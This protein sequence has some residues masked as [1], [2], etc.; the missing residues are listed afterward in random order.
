M[1]NVSNA[2]ATLVAANHTLLMKATLTLADSTV[3]NLTSDDF[4]AGSARFEQ[5]V[6]SDGSFDI[7]G[8]IVGTMS[9][10]LAN[11]GGKFDSYDLGGA[12]IIPYV[13]KLLPNNSYEWLRLGT[14]DVVK[15]DYYGGTI[16]ITCYDVLNRLASHKYSELSVTYPIYPQALLTA[17]GTHCGFT[18][19]YGTSPV[20]NTVSI[21]RAPDMEMTLLDAAGYLAQMMGYWLV[22]DVTGNI[23]ANWYDTTA[24]DPG[25]TPYAITDSFNSMFMTEDV[26]ITGVQV[27]ETDEVTLD[28]DNNEVNGN[29]GGTYLSGTSD[30]CLTIPS[31]PFIAY[32]TGQTVAANLYSRVGGMC[33]RPYNNS[34]PCDPVIEAGD[35]VVVTDRHGDTHNAYVTGVV[36]KP[37]GAMETRSTAKSPAS[38]SNLSA[39][40]LAMAVTAVK[41]SMER[42]NQVAESAKAIAEATDQHFWNDTNGVHVSTQDKVPNGTRNILINSVG[43][44][45]RAVDN[46]LAELSASGVKFYDG[47]GNASTNETASFGSNG[48]KIGKVDE[49]HLSVNSSAIEIISSTLQTLL[50]MSK[51]TRNIDGVNTDLGAITST[52]PL[53]L[54]HVGA[55]TSRLYMTDGTNPNKELTRLV[56]VLGNYTAEI[57]ANANASL[58]AEAKMTAT[59]TQGGIKTAQVDVAASSSGS[60]INL[61]G[62]EVLVGFAA[63]IVYEDKTVTVPSTAAGANYSSSAIS[64][65]KTGY[66]PIGCYQ[67]WWDS[68]TSQNKFNDYGTH[69]EAGN[70]YVRLHN[71]GTAAASGSLKC[72][73][74][75]VKLELL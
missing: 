8:A 75:Y 51:Q 57:E 1:R 68:G 41:A 58:G 40:P 24:F 21:T 19:S 37:D 3:L 13:G 70:L 10:T 38:N 46:Y 14:Y 2:F 48:A 18:V 26:T 32:G 72:R 17:I 35:A 53:L 15:P 25:K 29:A 11:Q 61:Q 39:S 50:S 73:I 65:L 55:G 7:G 44:L 52:M 63:P 69:V 66:A 5:A 4:M 36:L 12:T 34:M 62:D 71:Y 20:N 30:Y 67:T 56:E 33:F 27:T 28:A 49:T 64:V 60:L 6:S 16:G 31:N 43:I 47:L 9:V 54:E 22:C 59:S 74:L 42:T 23:T 45:L